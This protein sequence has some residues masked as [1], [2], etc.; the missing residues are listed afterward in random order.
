MNQPSRVVRL[1][2]TLLR[3]VQRTVQFIEVQIRFSGQRLQDQATLDHSK[4]QFLE[5]LQ[6]NAR[7]ELRRIGII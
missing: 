6:R 5:Y 2:R 4:K 7:H 1:A 3:D